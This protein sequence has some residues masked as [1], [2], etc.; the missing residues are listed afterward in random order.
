V[1]NA[2]R[3]LLSEAKA[4]VGFSPSGEK[5]LIQIYPTKDGCEVFVTKL[6]AI[7]SSA[8]K[9]LSRSDRVVLIDEQYS[10]YRF[11]SLQDIILASSASDM[12]KF[13]PEFYLDDNG[14][15]Y[16]AI[17]ENNVFTSKASLT[18]LLE[19]SV[20]IPKTVF[21]YIKEH[22]RRILPKDIF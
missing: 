2:L 14:Y 11:E 13:S 10:I 3:Q 5:L 22:A 12:L 17:K 8:E 6:G 1:K 15:Y 16:V 9:V 21:P 4:S 7:S 20:E 18:Q 19:Y